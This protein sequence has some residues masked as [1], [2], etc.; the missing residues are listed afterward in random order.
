MFIAHSRRR[1][2]RVQTHHTT[3][4]DQIKTTQSP[5]HGAAGYL[6]V[7]APPSTREPLWCEQ[8]AGA[9][10]APA[11]PRRRVFC[12]RSLNMRD[13]RAVGWDMD[14]TVRG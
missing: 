6:D 11:E 5:P 14:Y 4:H 10:P 12:N 8:P 1:C 13:V 9:P 2:Q 7:P 3:P